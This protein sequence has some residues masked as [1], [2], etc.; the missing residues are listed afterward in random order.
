M[1]L[2]FQP[3]WG[4]GTN[5]RDAPYIHADY[6]LRARKYPIQVKIRVHRK[7]F[8]KSTQHFFRI[9]FFANT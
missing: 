4:V 5:F 8:S 2:Q 6:A 9:G 7:L 3:I 1:R